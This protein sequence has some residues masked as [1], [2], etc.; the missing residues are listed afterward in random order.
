MRAGAASGRLRAPDGD[1]G[2][3]TLPV[4]R[5]E[6]DGRL[7]FG[8]QIQTNKRQ[9]QNTKTWRQ[10]HQPVGSLID[11]LSSI[12]HSRRIIETPKHP[13]TTSERLQNGECVRIYCRTGTDLH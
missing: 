8:I 6:D 13:A 3:G 4:I 7:P 10:P 1:A 12:F 9:R 11:M 5:R 2:D